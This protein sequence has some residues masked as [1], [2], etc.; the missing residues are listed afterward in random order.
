M[1]W[2]SDSYIRGG[3]G[4]KFRIAGFDVETEK[5]GGKVLFATYMMEGDSHASY[6]MG[7]DIIDRLIS[8]ISGHPEFI[9]YAHNANYDWRYFLP[10]IR[11]GRT[12]VTFAL[13]NDNS[14]FSIAF[15]SDKRTSSG[16]PIKVKMRD[17]YAIWDRTL[18]DLAD[19]FC[20]EYPKGHIDFDAGI[21]FDPK[22]QVHIDYA[23]RDV[24][25]LVHGIRR[26]NDVVLDRYG[27]N[28]RGT[29]ASTAL[30]AW[31]RMLEKNERYFNPRQHEDFIRSAYF[32]GLV[33]LTDTKERENLKTYDISSSYPFQMEEHGVPYGSISTTSRFRSDV[34]GIYDV[35]VFAPDTIRVPI[36]PL[37]K[38][39]GAAVSV[40]WPRG[41]F[42]TT[43]TSIELDF[44]ISKG[45]RLLAVHKGIIF[46]K[47]I[48]PF[49]KFVGTAKKIRAD[50]KGRAEETAAKRIQNSLYGKYG[51][52]RE[53]RCI[54]HAD[55]LNNN[56][57][58]CTPWDENGDFYVRVEKQ[59]DMM[60]LPQWAVWITA[61]G[62][63]HLLRTVYD[64]L[65]VENVV[66]GDTDSVTTSADMPAEMLG[67]EYGKFQL[68]K[69]WKRFRAIAP[70]VYAGQLEGPHKLG[71][72]PFSDGAWYGAAK[73]VPIKPKAEL[74]LK[75]GQT[76]EAAREEYHQNLF[77]DIYN[78]GI[79]SVDIDVLPSLMVTMRGGSANLRRVNRKSTN[80]ENSQNW[81]R[82]ENGEIWPR[83]VSNENN[84]E[85]SCDNSDD[86]EQRDLSDVA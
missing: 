32:G 51:A 25:I 55:E 65:G 9:W 34:P 61:N 49:K 5:L 8:V 12:G 2:T 60:A 57:L 21:I 46:E 59:E 43:V 84:S 78:N 13:R 72:K 76:A 4:K 14:I 82:L 48:Y 6:I 31:Q 69:T 44:A 35:T 29:I 71:G 86:R 24:E 45:Y 10:F 52:R 39:A 22:N 54:Y 11:A 16:E 70:K 81:L 28:L 23:L 1:V 66:Y 73:G 63:L 27:V 37:R 36:L 33:F 50:F 58:N 17:S 19:S 85:Q 53:R 74:R 64:V 56:F 26:F 40:L 68:E 18:A 3:P 67:K 30:A 41:K 42:R 7:T 83:F 75:K 15:D 47:I 77:R 38:K 80:V 20:P 79:T 62:R